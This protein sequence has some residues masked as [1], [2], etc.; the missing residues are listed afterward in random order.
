LFNNES[1]AFAN[2]PL[3]DGQ[4]NLS[5]TTLDFPEATYQWTGPN[6]FSSTERNPPIIQEADAATYAGEYT[7]V[8]TSA[9]GCVSPPQT[10]QVVINP[11]PIAPEVQNVTVCGSGNAI[12]EVLNPPTGATFRWYTLEEGGTPIAGA[13]GPTLQINNVTQETIRYV[14]V[15]QNNCEGPRVPVTAFYFSNVDTTLNINGSSLCQSESSATVEIPQS[16]T[17]VIYQVFLGNTAVSEPV[18][19]TGEALQIIVNAT[20]LNTGENTVTIRANF[21]NCGPVNMQQQP[22]ITRWQVT[23][24]T[25][26]WEGSLQICEGESKVLTATTGASYSWSNGASTPSITVTQSG[27]FTVTVTDANGCVSTSQQVVVTVNPLPQPVI[28]VDGETELCSGQTT[29][30]VA[31]GGTTYLWSTGATTASI[32]VSQAGSYSVTAF[33][34]S[35]QATSSAVQV[36]VIPTPNPVITVEGSLTLCSGQTTTLVASGGTT[37]LWSTGATTASITISQAGTYSVTAF[38]G[39]CQATSSAVQVVVNPSPNPIITVE[40]SLALC[41]GQTTTLVASGGT[42]YLWST[43]A[44]TASIT[45]SQAGT[46]SVTAFNGSCQATSSAVQVSVTPT[47]NPI[48]TV[49]GS[50]ALCLGQT[51]TL[52]ASGGTTYLW[53][54]GATTASITISQAG[55]YSVTAFNGS[56]QA[57]SSAVTVTVTSAPSTPGIIS[58]NNQLC[59]NT[60]QTYSIA[61]VGG[62]TS[63]QWIIPVG[64]TGTSTTNT[65]TVNPGTTGGQIRVVAI[66]NCGQS[67]EQVFNV[68]ITQVDNSVS[69]T[70]P[71][72]TAFA[73]G[74]TYQWFNC[75]TNQAIPGATQAVFTATE[76]GSYRVLVTQNGCSEFSTCLI[77]NTLS[78]NMPEINFSIQA[79][80]NPAQQLIE[81]RISPAPMETLQ[82]SLWNVLGQELNRQMATPV[83]NGV[84][85]LRVEHLPHGN[86]F[87]KVYTE[88]K[89][90]VV[91]FIKN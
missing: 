78:V 2:T 54:T 83:S 67:E 62:A 85:S 1:V 15:V 42:T 11:I 66:N 5:L 39:T 51:T 41:S 32:T 4:G 89:E 52:V 81:L 53:S 59:D 3:C 38:N 50:L 77:V 16:E 55:T 14:S 73:T 87:I 57:T 71:Q 45:V 43:G 64:W 82:I 24:P 34:G 56:C 70:G 36:S 76:D 80:P 20:L 48:I 30:L 86:Y 12:L 19:G 69:Q 35:C 8:V 74:A 6:G 18:T 47:P 44:T 13:T 75:I 21:P 84:Y 72:L 90:Q 27:T 9:A 37:Y 26:S 46:Y 49:D 7:L 91:P 61:P 31:S 40:G 58:G 25:I 29:T 28:T 79:Y 17:G 63:Y 22:V 68:Q 10:V 23:L 60:Q 65:I 88:G 33:N